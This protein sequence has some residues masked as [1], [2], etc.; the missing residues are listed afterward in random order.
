MIVLARAAVVPSFCSRRYLG[1]PSLPKG[2][3]HICLWH[4]VDLRSFVRSNPDQGTVIDGFFDR[5]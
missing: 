2:T 5:I 4:G 1:R 3:K